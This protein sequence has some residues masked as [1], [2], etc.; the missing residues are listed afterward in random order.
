MIDT[1]EFCQNI[2]KKRH[3]TFVSS[4]YKIDQIIENRAF[5]SE[6]SKKKELENMK[7]KILKQY[8]D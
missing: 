5:T 2:K 6:V 1:V 3:E 8:H 7:K 4:F